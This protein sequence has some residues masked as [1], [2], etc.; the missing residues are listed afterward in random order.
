M[1]ARTR[2]PLTNPPRTNHSILWVLMVMMVLALP[3]AVTSALAG[4]PPA[5]S[6]ITSYDPGGLDMA[7]GVALD[8]SGNVFATGIADRDG[9]QDMVTVKLNWSGAVQW[10]RSVDRGARDRG[11]SVVTDADGSVYAAGTINLQGGDNVIVLKYGATGDAEWT[12]VIDK[13]TSETARA[14]ARDPSGNVLVAGASLSGNGGDGFVAKLTSNG[15]EVWAKP[16]NVF[17]MDECFAVTSDADGNV[18]VAGRVVKDGSFDVLVRK[19]D[20]AGSVQW[21]KYVSTNGHEEA[22]GVAADAS[23]NV[24]VSGTTATP[25]GNSSRTDLLVARFSPTGEL[26]WQK[27]LDVSG[28]DDEGRGVAVD[29]GGNLFVTGFGRFDDN[30]DP[31]VVK[32]TPEGDE[33]WRQSTHGSGIDGTGPIA[34]APDGSRIV[35]AGA[36]QRDGRDFNYLFIGFEQSLPTAAFL[37]SPASP[38]AGEP[39]AFEDVSAPGDAA[40]ASWEWDFGDGAASTKQNPT[41]TYAHGGDYTVRLVV[42]DADN[43]RAEAVRTLTVTGTPA[44]GAALGA[45]DDPTDLGTPEESSWSIPA[46]GTVAI[47]GVLAAAAIAAGR[48]RRRG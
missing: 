44:P 37:A 25:V 4:A 29:D 33:V 15:E 45:T 16:I 24:F 30:K 9:Q 36:T 34:V 13:G 22:R 8:F 21:T 12:T 19:F 6:L 26:E 28:G 17:F 35:T 2:V 1:F 14:I 23:G 18:I 10:S 20:S 41:H 5:P 11:A 42:R 3:S 31:F 46:A 39:V 43:N 47:A 48:A 7:E 32:L 27:T 40:L 38:E